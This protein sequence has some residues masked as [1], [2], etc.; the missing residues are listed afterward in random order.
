M[1]RGARALRVP[2][3]IAEVARAVDRTIGTDPTAAR[4][5]AER[6]LEMLMALEKR[7]G[8]R[9]HKGHA[10]HNIAVAIVA[11]DSDRARTY[12]HAAHA[13]DARTFPRRAP[14]TWAWLARRMLQ[15]LYG[16]RS[17]GTR[18]LEGVARDSVED[19]L[20]LAAAFEADQG[21]DLGTYRGLIGGWRDET[22]L[23]TFSRDDLVFVG[24]SHANPD[25]MRALRQAVVDV[26]LEP[27]V[28]IEFRDRPGDNPHVKSERLMARCGRAL[29]D[30]SFS[31]GQILE[32]P[33]A[34]AAELPAFV[35]FIGGSVRAELHASDMTKGLLA[36]A[37]IEPEATVGTEQLREAARAWLRG[38]GIA[39]PS[40]ASRS[41][42]APAG[43]IELAP[44][45]ASPYVGAEPSNSRSFHEYSEPILSGE[46][47]VPDLDPFSVDFEPP[48]ESD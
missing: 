26:G 25:H 38:T 42:L 28:V 46:R 8:R 13:E 10:L 4:V 31:T 41:L 30:L 44:G 48:S 43:A 9:V 47:Y 3:G 12:F 7:T 36:R 20:R 14:K 34:L 6:E 23:D 11:I 45:S 15:D 22:E 39:R 21:P 2:A 16:E 33:M 1:V 18:A 17:S 40:L 27:V 32:L 35:G 24:G 29:F 5:L 37:G 19:P